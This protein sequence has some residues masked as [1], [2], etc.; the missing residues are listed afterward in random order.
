MKIFDI[1]PFSERINNTEMLYYRKNGDVKLNG[2]TFEISNGT[3]SFFT[4][5]NC[6][7]SY[8]YK[9][10]TIIDKINIV[11]NLSG[12]GNVSIC[13][14]NSCG[15]KVLSEKAFDSTK[16]FE[17]HF[18]IHLSDISGTVLYP[19]IKNDDGE[20]CSVF[21][22]GYYTNEA[23]MRHIDLAIAICTYKREKYICE[24][25]RHFT[26]G[27]IT[28][29]VFVVD[30]GQ[31][32]KKDDLE[33]KNSILVPNRNYGGS[34]GFA[35]GMIEAWDNRDKFTHI[36]L[37]DDDI[38]IEYTVI[39]KTKILL[40]LLKAEYADSA[41]NGTMLDLDKPCIQFE[42]G[43]IWEK[44]DYKASISGLDLSKEDDI[45]SNETERNINY[46]AWWF[47]CM[48][49]NVVEKYG[50]PLPFFIKADDI[51]YGV[52]S[53]KNIITLSGIAVW[54]E[55][56]FKKYSSYLTYYF[57]RNE[58]VA[59]AIRRKTNIGFILR[60]IAKVIS[61]SLVTYNYKEL[62]F[63][64]MAFNDFMK[65][66]EF[67]I[68]TDEENLNNTLREMDYK[69]LPLKELDSADRFPKQSAFNVDVSKHIAK[70]SFMQIIT[71][72]GYLLPNLLFKKN[73]NTALVNDRT[74]NS[75]YR[76]K[77]VLIYNSFQETGRIVGIERKYLFKGIGL[78]F[79]YL[80]RL[81]K[82]Y[83]KVKSDYQTREKDIT[84][85]DFWR[86]HLGMNNNKIQ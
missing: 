13:E 51:E 19:V 43:G 3:L 81:A 79:K 32:L 22:C 12:K 35:R 14:Y 72:N 9:K 41:V 57:V 4:Y 59:D 63:L 77:K 85:V 31:T 83:K 36:L 74:F 30:N 6:F 11:I 60:R 66:P 62:I 34:G 17:M 18:E 45:I 82:Y 52:R 71:L 80:F 44:Y 33:Y 37:M 86:N 78:M 70:P 53:S 75:F 20:H 5:F 2:K 69:M 42:T 16:P 76:Y 25:L 28:D 48:P 8:K 26:V 15:Q 38:S 68:S 55:N 21:N 67:F 50:L 61:K 10:Y 65:G 24:N 54:H 46:G 29:T 49:I 73:Y 84:S 40:S 7:P 1:Q 27:G 64:D 58:L 23:P 56:L 47:M 39:E